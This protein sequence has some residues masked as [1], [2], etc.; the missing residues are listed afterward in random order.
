MVNVLNRIST[1]S[2]FNKKISD[3]ESHIRMMIGKKKDQP[4]LIHVII[5]SGD[6][7]VGKTFRANKI[8]SNQKIRRFVIK[9]GDITPVQLY[10]LLWDY[11]DGII[12]LDDVNS[13]IQDSKSGAA[14]LKACT[15]SIGVRKLNWDKQNP[16]CIHVSKYDLKMKTN[17]DIQNK[18]DEIAKS[19]SK[20]LAIAHE[21]N[22]T[23]PDMFYFTGALIILTNKP[24]E[25]IDKYTEG[26]LSNRGYHLE[27][28]FNVDGAVALIKDIAPKLNEFNDIPIQPKNVTKAV[29]FLTTPDHIKM[30]KKHNLL[31]TIRTLGKIALECEWG[32]KLDE[33]TLVNNIESPA[34]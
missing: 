25:V 29:K 20:R 26:A 4:M 12:V 31:P 5:V 6:K 3:Y 27:M 23:F 8:L 13:I 34:Y 32:H 18:M 14:L 11:N 16:N 30:Y 7:G 9:N 17:K 24:L 2:E 10:K 28:L 21:N 19:G 33:D 1:L 22:L 15:D